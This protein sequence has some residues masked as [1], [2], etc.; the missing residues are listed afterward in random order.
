VQSIEKGKAAS[1]ETYARVF[2]VLGLR[3]EL[4]GT[5]ARRRPGTIRDEDPVHAAMGELEA[6]RIGGFG[7]VVSI[8][9]PYQHY[10]FAGRAD[11]VAWDLEHRALLHL[12]NRTRFPNIQEAFGSYN[13]KRSYL[14]Q[15][16]ADRLA[17]GPRG[18]H[19]VTH[20]IVALWSA[21]VLHTL[22]LRTQSFAAVCPDNSEAF[23]NWWVGSPPS[24]GVTSTFIAL[25]PRATGR[26][27]AW[28]DLPGAL[29][30]RPRN[31]G[32]ADAASAQ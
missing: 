25:D 22:R 32:Y 3:G 29:V 13:A 21:E 4:R 30:T 26:Q 12:E 8:D 23:A 10:Q 9:E 20:A 2:T 27:R 16:L 17:I 11:L 5:D 31:R 14:A 6:G 15:V 24:V 28:I 1:L 7:F 19:S 18:W